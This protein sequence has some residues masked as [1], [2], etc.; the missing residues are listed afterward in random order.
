M[1]ASRG[2]GGV[3]GVGGDGGRWREME[4]LSLI[5]G[6]PFQVHRGWHAVDP[7]STSPGDL[8][9]RGSF[10]SVDHQPWK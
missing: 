7:Y 5:T 3:G 4:E 10:R 9:V 6:L 8:R 2:V 1:K